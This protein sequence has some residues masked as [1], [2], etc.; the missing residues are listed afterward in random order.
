[1]QRT[2]WEGSHARGIEEI[3]QASLMKNEYVAS[4]AQSSLLGGLLSMLICLYSILASLFS[5]CGRSS[6]FVPEIQLELN[7]AFLKS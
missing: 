1:M 7:I 6:Y 5:L 3:Y 4:L 2:R